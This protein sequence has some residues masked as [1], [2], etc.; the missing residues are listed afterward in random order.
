MPAA[1]PGHRP[2]VPLPGTGPRLRSRRPRN[3][4]TRTLSYRRIPID[5]NGQPRPS[6]A[7][8]PPSL[9]LTSLK[10]PRV[11]HVVHLRSRRHRDRQQ[12]FI[13]EGYRALHHAGTH[14]YPVRDLFVCPPL[15]QGPNEAELIASF[16]GRG[17]QI[18]ETSEPVFRKMAY[19]DRPDGLLG[20]APQQHR[21][22]GDLRWKHPPLFLIAEAIEK[23]G[24]L[25]TILRSAD[26]AG[27]DGLLLCD[28][29]TDLFNP[30]VVRASI[31]T[32]FCVP[33]A[34][35]DSDETLDWLAENGTRMLAATPHTDR[36]YTR[37]DMT[38]PLAIAVGTEQYGLSD[39]W[40]ARADLTVQIP[41]YGEA[42]SLNVAT[43]TTLLLYEAVRQRRL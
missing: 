32:L 36:L 9:R 4:A 7:E 35:A 33:V 25:G 18:I 6:D 2:A 13:I 31:G 14:A 38:G 8:R 29:R 26:A 11:K 3:A 41:M 27:V 34:E 23:P 37:T 12:E 5:T 10:N 1:P 24:N 30:N 22:L 19:R 16:R 28:R 15:F 39:R 17:T 40:L 21:T 20:V 43:A 42:D